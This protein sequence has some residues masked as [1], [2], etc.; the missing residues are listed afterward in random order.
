MAKSHDM[1]NNIQ[2][3]Y[4][5]SKKLRI[6]IM[7]FCSKIKLDQWRIQDFPKGATNPR[8]GAKLLFGIIFAENCK[9]MKKIGLRV[10]RISPG[11]ATIDF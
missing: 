6:K 8:G 2:R 11:S 3:E 1:S 10:G 4:I 5:N 9:K 7:L